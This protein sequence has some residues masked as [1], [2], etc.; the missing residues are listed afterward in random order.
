MNLYIWNGIFKFSTESIRGSL[1]CRFIRSV[2]DKTRIFKQL[3]IFMDLKN[4]L[5]FNQFIHVEGNIQEK[6]HV[7][8]INLN[9]HLFYS[10]TLLIHNKKN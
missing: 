10:W 6:N 5:K 4:N 9:Q 3:D 1:V 2:E 8:L 7:I